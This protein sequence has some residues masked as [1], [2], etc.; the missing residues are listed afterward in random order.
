MKRLII[1]LIALAAIS[2]NALAVDDEQVRLLVSKLT[3]EEKAALMKF[4]SPAIP[5]LGIPEYNW[6]NEALHGVARNGYATMFPMPIGMAASFDDELL[7]EVFSA[8]SDEAI[9]K[10]RQGL[11]EKAD[12]PEVSLWYKG[13][14]VWTPNINIFRDPR[15]GRGME[16][17][18]EDLVFG[19]WDTEP[20]DMEE[21]YGKGF[22]ELY[23]DWEVWNLA[24]CGELGIRLDLAKADAE[25]AS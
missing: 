20:S 16:T 19:H 1:S 22:E 18:G 14:S 7:Y 13:L 9:V 17:Y 8:V 2:F 12:N 23:R 21:V 6:W 24:K 5:R 3:L 10:Y 15:W 4:D 25:K 11:K